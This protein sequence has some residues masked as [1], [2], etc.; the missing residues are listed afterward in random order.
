MRS[1]AIRLTCL[2]K[3]FAAWGSVDYDDYESTCS[4]DRSVADFDTINESAVDAVPAVAI[5]D[6]FGLGDIP[7]NDLLPIVDA[8]LDIGSALK[9][10][11]IPDP[12][13]FIRG[14][15]ALAQ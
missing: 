2:L 13:E 11:D 4:E 10:E 9:E 7:G 3:S 14:Y 1:P 5:G 6:F 8:W 12:M 15:E